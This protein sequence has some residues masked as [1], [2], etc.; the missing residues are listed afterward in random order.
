MYE[1]YFQAARTARILRK[2]L[3][4]HPSR[5]AR[6]GAAAL[7]RRGR[8]AGRRVAGGGVRMRRAAARGAKWTLRSGRQARYELG[9][10]IRGRSL[11]GA[12]TTDAPR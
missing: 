10:R 7:A 11:P 8:A 3:F 4:V 1:S 12:D 5:L 2:R 9:T 6:A